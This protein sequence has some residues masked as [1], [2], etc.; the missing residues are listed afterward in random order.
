M[1]ETAKTAAQ[2][3]WQPSAERV[4]DANLS[5]FINEVAQDVPSV[6]DYPSLYDWSVEHPADFWQRMWDFGGVLASRRATT[7]VDDLT[8]MPGASWFSGSR[9]NFAE[10]L[11]RYRDEQPALVFWNEQGRQGSWTYAELYAEVAR[12]A[13]A[14][15]AV[16]V[17]SGDRVAGF[18][19]NLPQ[20][21]M[22]ML[23]A[24]SLGAVWSSCSPDFGVKGVL[25]RFG[26]IQPKILVCAD[27]YR[28]AG[29]TFDSL[30]RVEQVLERIP[31]VERVLVVPYL[32]A[33]PDLSFSP[34]AVLWPDFVAPYRDVQ[35]LDFA[36]LPFDHPLY[37]MYSSGTTG[38]CPSAWCTAPGAPCLQH[39]KELMLHTDLKSRRPHLL[40]HHLRLDDVELAGVQPRR[41]RHRA[42]LR[43]VPHEAPNG[44]PLP[45]GGGRGYDDLRHQRQVPGLG[46]KRR[47][48]TAGGSRPEP[49]PGG[50]FHRLASGAGKL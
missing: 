15:K 1:S 3:V 19:P 26:Q 25:D 41:R 10:N 21:V 47:C 37:I 13:A 39:L 24:T 29:K 31:D 7:V 23:A 44:H 43:R 9:L 34:K 27:G 2:L 30:E 36:Q 6:T 49:D 40:L 18:L 5:R 17:E 45:A 48:R 8:R 46:G 14:M 28:F 16:G 38:R 11:L 22:A 12:L 20:T 32:D 50:A 4:A 33:N 42:A 35:E